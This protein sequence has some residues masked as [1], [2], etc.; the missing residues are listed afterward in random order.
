MDEAIV[1]TEP[2]AASEESKLIRV[3]EFFGIAARRMTLAECLA[4]LDAGSSSSK[5]RM[6]STVGGFQKLVTTLESRKD[7]APLGRFH[8][9]FVYG[10]GDYTDLES[11]AAIIPGNVKLTRR[12]SSGDWFVTDTLPEFCKSLSGVR[13]KSS[14]PDPEFG[15]KLE[16]T[17]QDVIS[18]ISDGGLS[19]FVRFQCHGVPVFL[20]TAAAI[21]DIH[22]NLTG[23]DFDIRQHFFTSVPLVLYTQWA[24]TEFCWKAPETP[25]CLVIDDPLLKPRYGFLKFQL[26]LDL[27]RKH[28]F[29]TSIA[30]IPWNWRR[31]SSRVVRL[32]KENPERLSLSIH[33]CDHTGGEFG[34]LNVGR[35]AWKSKESLQR[36]WRHQSRTG[37]PHDA[38]MVFP[39]GV[40][41]ARAME[42]L[43]RSRF[44]GVVNSEVFS[45]DSDPRPIKIGDYW[46]VAVLNYSD[47]PIFT[48]RY[49]S[50]GIEN[51]AFDI[52]VGKPCLVVAHHNDC[53]D[54]C[55]HI[56]EFMDRLNKLNVPLRWTSLSEVIRRSFRQREV[57][58]GVVEVEMYGTQIRIEN[59]YGL[60]TVF[61]CR[62]RESDTE[63]ISA[64]HVD[65]ESIAF[66]VDGD[67]QSIAF[68]I[69]LAPG[70]SRIVTMAYKEIAAADNFTGESLSYKLKAMARRYLS[71]VRDNYVTRKSFST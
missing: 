6:L 60:R 20:T 9:V 43:K 40:F 58:Q 63:H 59:A 62:K 71:E 3:L 48:R 55:R 39:Q 31:N 13:V 11:I 51:F 27:M 56:T 17:E 66:E 2:A 70:E 61:R 36:M 41:S 23:R 47:F 8:S 14:G 42:V 52:L 44:I 26:L 24:F 68:E 57:S 50:A 67:R 37:L 5:F 65:G 34:S 45:T 21:I 64:V 54:D 16:R 38:V 4:A 32:F 69:E 10:A 29:S 46:N 35:L 49:A 18:L 19:Y 15:W 25:A 22:E 30:F 1:L 33:G 7:T 53:H 28:N 12:T